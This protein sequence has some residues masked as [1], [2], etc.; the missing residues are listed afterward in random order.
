MKIEFISK[1][2]KP[3]G[4]MQEEIDKF[5]DIVIKKLDKM[6]RYFDEHVKIK[7]MLKGIKDEFILEVT[8]FVD[9]SNIMR[10][11]VKAK[12]MFSTIDLVIPKLERQIRKYR[13]KL[14]RKLKD[15]TFEDKFAP[16]DDGDKFVEK[17][18]KLAR[19]K[20]IELRKISVTDA[21]GEME[22]SDHDFYVFINEEN[23]LVNLIYKRKDGDVGLLDLVY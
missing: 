17:M 19:V 2:N 10:G 20:T 23:G 11:E 9:G 7:V 21:I 4:K 3:S 12:D 14:G 8:I 6:S 1:I 13:T 18:A 15:D 5:E 22:L 16:Q